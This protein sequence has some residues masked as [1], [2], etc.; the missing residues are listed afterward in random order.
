MVKQMIYRNLKYVYLVIIAILLIIL[1][2]KSCGNK[3]IT[4]NNE[5]IKARIVYLNRKADSTKVAANVSEVTRI[6]YVTKWRAAI[7]DTIY[8]PCEELI[9]ICDSI[10]SIDSTQISQ[11]RQVITLSD[12]IILN[13]KIIIHNNSLDAICLKKSI[14]KQRRHK[15][16]ALIGLG[17]IT[18][19][20]VVK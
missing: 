3:V 14:R 2:F 16:L 13:Q 15:N 7:H 11:L 10:I 17:V 9:I 19:L 18:V 5:P 4:T 12:S 20:S 8:K 6:K 1:A